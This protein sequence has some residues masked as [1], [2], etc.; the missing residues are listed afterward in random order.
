MDLASIRPNGLS[1]KTVVNIAGDGC[2]RMNMNDR[3]SCDIDSVSTGRGEQSCVL[4]MVRQW[5]NL[6]YNQH[7]P[8]N[9][10]DAVDFIKLAGALERNPCD[11][12]RICRRFCKAGKMQRP[13]VLDC[14]IDQDDKI[15]ADALPRLP[16]S[17]G[18]L[19]RWI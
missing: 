6:F 12:K 5:Q 2:F 16:R 15:V 13:V 18:C 17:A 19:M 10:D 7:I 1:G 11:N 3:N 9:L 4:G 8:D 14:Q